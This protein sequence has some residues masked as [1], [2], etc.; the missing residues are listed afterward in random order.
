MMQAGW[1]MA[2]KSAQSAVRFIILTLPVTSTQITTNA[3]QITRAHSTSRV[4]QLV[5]HTARPEFAGLRPLL[6]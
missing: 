2:N 3:K 1:S 4:L 5:S 6:V